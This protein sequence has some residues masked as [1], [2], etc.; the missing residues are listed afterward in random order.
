LRALAV[1]NPVAGSGRAL[2][3][4]EALRLRVHGLSDWE[5]ATTERPG[6]ARELASAA[7]ANGCTRVVV[8][9][10]DGTVCEAANGL[11]HSATALA[12]VPLGTGNDT[13]R[14]LG[15]PLDAT[16][17]AGLAA[18]GHARLIDLGHLETSRTRMYF[19]NVAGFGFDAEVA[20]RV[21]RI[22]RLIGGTLPY[23]AGVLQ[24]LWQFR[25][26]R[27]SINVD[28]KVII[29]GRTFMVAV[30]NCPSYGGGMRIA[31]D[32]RHDDGALDICVVSDLSRLEI[33][34]MVPKL[35]TGGH[36]GHPAV[37]LLRGHT[38][39]AESL[40]AVRCHA[41]GEVVGTLPATFGIVPNALRCVMS[42]HA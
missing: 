28:G 7:S 22:P 35:Y 14:N 40:D 13:A 2:R 36:A 42:E 3:V 18:R 17:A 8:F 39:T 29:D 34:R 5:C 38:V 32:A 20:W 11:V 16:A 26:P 41:D 12:I 33:L 6:H 37:R 24:T 1:V 31:P 19:A 9:G 21:T 30:A 25:S 23:V 27:M 15:V 4:W 10:G